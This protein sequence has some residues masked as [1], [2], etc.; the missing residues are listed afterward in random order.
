[1]RKMLL[2]LPVVALLLAAGVL[3]TELGGVFAKSGPAVA[4]STTETAS[5]PTPHPAQ[6]AWSE[7]AG[8][9]NTGK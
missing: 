9:P 2:T 3:F 6:P 4:N 5:A 7:T 1:M 8:R